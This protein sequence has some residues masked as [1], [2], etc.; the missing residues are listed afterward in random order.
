M[1]S[2]PSPACRPA[3]PLPLAAP[4]F[5]LLLPVPPLLQVYL[6]RKAQALAQQLHLRF[7]G[8]DDRFK[9]VD[10]AQLAA[11]SGSFVCVWL[12]ERE[13]RRSTARQAALELVVWALIQV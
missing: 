10:T 5:P 7:R 13:R 12:G 3:G 9:F 4:L 8:S 11:D 2:S 1:P 6:Y